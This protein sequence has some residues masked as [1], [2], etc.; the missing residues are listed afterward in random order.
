MPV[1]DL[2]KGSKAPQSGKR[3]E[4]IETEY[5]Y[6]NPGQPRTVFDDDALDELAQSIQQVGLIQP[7]LVRRIDDKHYELIAGERRL[8]AIKKIGMKTVPCIVHAGID[9]E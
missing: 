4:E 9:E 1:L 7:L 3:L 6:P 2:F 8:R 5:I